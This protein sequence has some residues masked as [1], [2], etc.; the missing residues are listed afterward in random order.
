MSEFLATSAIVAVGVG[1]GLAIKLPQFRRVRKRSTGRILQRELT[2]DGATYSV[3]L[4]KGEGIWRPGKN[5]LVHGPGRGTYTRKDHPEGVIYHLV[6]AA[7]DGS[8][9]HFAGPIAPSFVEGSV[10]QARYSTAKKWAPLLVLVLWAL[11]LGCVALGIVVAYVVSDLW[12]LPWWAWF[13]IALAVSAVLDRALFR[14]FAVVP[15]VA[16]Q[17][18]WSPRD[19]E[20]PSGAT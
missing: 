1:I 19:D 9:A 16:A 18:P 14:G 20:T 4:R 6:L 5:G 3:D 12:G 10:A 11:R 7:K 17:R 2:H 13:L 15:K 8:V